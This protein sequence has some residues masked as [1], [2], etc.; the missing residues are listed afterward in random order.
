MHRG[1]FGNWFLINQ[2]LPRKIFFGTIFVILIFAFL[3]YMH[4]RYD[5]PVEKTKSETTI[6]NLKK[7]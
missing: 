4:I 1:Y 2:N 3:I 5:K 6:E 7:D